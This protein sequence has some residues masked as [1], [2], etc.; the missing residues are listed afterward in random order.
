[1]EGQTAATKT[2]NATSKGRGKQQV[3]NVG[4]FAV[5]TKVTMPRKIGSV[6]QFSHDP[7]A[8]QRVVDN[9]FRRVYVIHEGITPDPMVYGA[10]IET[11]Y[12]L[13][14][15]L[16]AKKL[17]IALGAE[18]SL[19]SSGLLT[20]FVAMKLGGPANLGPL[21]DGYGRISTDDRTWEMIGQVAWSLTYYGRAMADLPPPALLGVVQPVIARE[22]A[23]FL[24][25]AWPRPALPLL[26]VC[27]G[28]INA[29]ASAEPTHV[30]AFQQANISMSVPLV[31]RGFAAY[32]QFV[33]GVQRPPLVQW[34]MN[35]GIDLEVVDARPNNVPIAADI[36]ALNVRNVY[37]VNWRNDQYDVLVREYSR[38]VE[39]RVQPALEKAQNWTRFAGFRDQGAPWQLVRREA[40]M[41]ASCP[42]SL[43][44]DSRE[45]GWMLCGEHVWHRMRPD[46]FMLNVESTQLE[47]VQAFVDGQVRPFKN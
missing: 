1:M 2:S 32:A 15:A 24:N 9:Y 38:E 16:L 36:A 39:A 41:A 30:F 37:V 29:W 46:T 7:S 5:F 8:F 40:N 43:P 20:R 33:A 27:R 11:G 31:E 35:L 17:A 42:E 13:M 26:E 44:N 45:L 34:A 28:I 47:A 22:E 4:S 23:Y 3:A 18:D 25:A 12:R 21:V 6:N 14:C 10:F 19:A